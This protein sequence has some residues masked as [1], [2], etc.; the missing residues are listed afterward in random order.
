[1][2]DDKGRNFKRVPLEVPGKLLVPA[3]GLEVLCTI[4]NLSP[5]GAELR[6][7]IADLPDG[8]V[9]LLA[10]GVGR[11]E[12][13]IAWK[14]KGRCGLQFNAS[15]K[16]AHTAH[17]P[18]RRESEDDESALRRKRRMVTNRL[19]EFTRENGVVVDCEVLDLAPGG[20]TLKTKVRPLIGEYVLMGGMVGRVVRHH[21]TGIALEFI[22]GGRGDAS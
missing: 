13:K 7:D 14:R 22:V 11:F 16:R 5:G 18:A 20:I 6:G 1:M 3:T 9:V 12:G 21:E 15:A 2:A 10:E 17:Q 4:A 8:P 19:S